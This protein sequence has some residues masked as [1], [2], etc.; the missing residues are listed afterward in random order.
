M[1][2]DVVGNAGGRST[3]Q[4]ARNLG[5]GAGG[6]M[7]HNNHHLSITSSYRR[8]GAG[9]ARFAFFVFFIG[10]G[11]MIFLGI[12]KVMSST[13]DTRGKLLQSWSNIVNDWTDTHSAQFTSL[14]PTIAVSSGTNV[15]PDVV[16]VDSATTITPNSFGE[17]S[18]S[19]SK[20]TTPSSVTDHTL[21]ATAK[22]PTNNAANQPCTVTLTSAKT[23]KTVATR[24]FTPLKQVGP[25]KTTVTSSMCQWYDSDYWHPMASIGMGDCNSVRTS[26]QQYNFGP[27]SCVADHYLDNNGCPNDLIQTSQWVTAGWDWAGNSVVQQQLNSKPRFTYDSTGGGKCW[28]YSDCFCTGCGHEFKTDVSK[29]WGFTGYG[30]W[31]NS[32]WTSFPKPFSQM[33]GTE[34]AQQCKQQFDNMGFHCPASEVNLVCFRAGGYPKKPCSQWCD[35]QDR[36]TAVYTPPTTYVTM[37]KYYGPWGHVQGSYPTYT[38][39]EATCEYSK[40][41]TTKVLSLDLALDADATTALT[42]GSKWA[43]GHLFQEQ[44]TVGGTTPFTKIAAT[45]DIQINVRSSVGPMMEGIQLTNGCGPSPPVPTTSSGHCFGPTQGENFQAG[46]ILLVIGGLLFCGPIVMAYFV[47]KG[48]INC[49]N[50]GSSSQNN[51]TY[52]PLINDANVRGQ[53][54]IVQQQSAVNNYIPSAPQSQQ[55]YPP[56]QQQEYIPVAQPIA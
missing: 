15:A 30:Y 23:K 6:G 49:L 46:M 53:T 5:L 34:K 21:S 3:N 11:V 28:D 51:T 10:G 24:T 48:I 31:Y 33:T 44:T 7:R 19:T 16:M 13:T 20:T 52:Q 42:T 37:S 39:K 41:T 38:Q 4:A 18:W 55:Y 12:S 45:V 9:C 22:C 36:Q 17:S 32:I 8:R 50:G 1:P 40:T 47:A 27:D 54:I 25:I 26:S 56:Q 14:Q 43:T 29:N 35:E 2:Y